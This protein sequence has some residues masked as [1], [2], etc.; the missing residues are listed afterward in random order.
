MGRSQADASPAGTH[1]LCVAPMMAWTDRHCRAFHRVL[2]PHARLY[3]EMVTADAVLH[4]PTERLLAFDPSEHPVALQL[5]GSEP[6]ALG[7]CARLA[8]ERGFDE[9]NLN[10]GCPSPRVQRGAFGACLMLEPRRVAACL[11][12]MRDACALPVTVK[13]RLGVDG[14][15]D[16]P[17]LRDFVGACANAGVTTFAVHARIAA[18]NG[19]S[20]AQN[21]TVPPL[22]YGR[23]RRL[24]REFPRLTVV[25]NGGIRDTEGALDALAWA[26]GVMVGRGAYRDPWWLAQLEHRLFGTALPGGPHAVLERYIADYV[27]RVLADGTRLHD[28]ARHLHGLFNG[29]PGAR[30]WRRHLSEETR[31]PGAG[32]EVLA[33]AAHLL[34]QAA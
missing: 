19:L 12:A 2:A 27:E 25:L 14:H 9:V 31:R 11:A 21:R 20:P 22:Q 13:C 10:V 5:G 32:A 24:K 33:T 3:T 26:D 4:G 23:V 8:Q 16:Y 7:R 15:D 30:A 17:F 34:P 18:L 29:M 6:G 1:V 28:I